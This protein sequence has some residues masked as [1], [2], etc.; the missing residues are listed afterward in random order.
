MSIGE[1]DGITSLFTFS[2]GVSGHFV[3]EAKAG[4]AKFDQLLDTTERGNF[5]QLGRLVQFAQTE[6]S[7]TGN[8]MTPLVVVD[9]G[10]E[11]TEAQKNILRRA[12][13]QCRDVSGLDLL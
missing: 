3:Y 13:V 6:A 9:V 1:I 12:G 8:Q 7:R 11:V 4:Q 10:I 2:D 5:K